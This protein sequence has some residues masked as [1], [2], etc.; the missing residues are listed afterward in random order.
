MQEF[1]ILTTL[2]LIVSFIPYIRAPFRTIETYFHELSHGLM[3]VFTFGKIHRIQLN[4][5]GSGHCTTSGGFRIFVLL[6]GYTGASIS[7]LLIYYIGTQ[8]K[9]NEAES[10]LYAVLVLLIFSTLMWVR[11]IPT[12]ICMILMGCLFYLPL[13]HELYEY[14]S[15]YLKFIGIYVC[16][17]AVRSPLD[18]IDGQDI[19]D[20]AELF[21]C[22]L[23]PEGVW[24]LAWVAFGSYC[25]YNIYY[26]SV[27][28]TF[29][30]KIL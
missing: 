6:A 25:M 30:T 9:V 4:F 7:G 3:A 22:T 18:L 14:T 13:K 8:I 28:N 17:S 2:A 19:G 12:L 11:H 16:L 21:K 29:I 1:I 10:F 15:I 5:D 20:G 27:Y 23:L 26:L 24:I